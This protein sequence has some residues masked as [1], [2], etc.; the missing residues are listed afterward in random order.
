MG[1]FGWVGSDQ[2]RE[3]RGVGYFER[4]LEYADG[5]FGA[6]YYWREVLNTEGVIV[7]SGGSGGKDKRYGGDEPC[8]YCM[9]S[10]EYL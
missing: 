1:G 10:T 7:T 6:G 2:G 9:C 5:S 4:E 3:R 8:M